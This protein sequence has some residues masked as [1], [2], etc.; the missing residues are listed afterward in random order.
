MVCI[1]IVNFLYIIFLKWACKK[2]GKTIYEALNDELG[3]DYVDMKTAQEWQ[4]N[5][6]V[7][8]HMNDIMRL[9]YKIQREGPHL[10][11][12]IRREIQDNLHM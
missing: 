10:G 2:Q 1:V 9:R 6:S 5:K 3:I 7:G 8:K 12:R 4:N 11:E